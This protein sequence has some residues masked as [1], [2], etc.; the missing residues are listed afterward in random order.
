MTTNLQLFTCKMEH[1]NEILT[2]HLQT[3]FPW[4]NF[5][6]DSNT[7]RDERG[8]IQFVS[9]IIRKM[10]GKI[11]S[12]APSQ[13]SKDIRDVVFPSAPFS[14]TY[15]CKKGKGVYILNDTIPDESDDYY[16]IFINTKS[17]EITIKHCSYLVRSQRTLEVDT[18]LKELYD[19]T[20]KIMEAAVNEGRMSYYEYGQLF[21][22]TVTFANGLKSRP[23]PNWSIRI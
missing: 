23:R 10:G 22:R 18:S 3:H 19:Q 21:K 2:R 17:K 16:Y 7:Q 20:M 9:Q 8:Y 13:Q 5:S 14:V 1:I 12:F 11:G 6:N 15:E 4:D